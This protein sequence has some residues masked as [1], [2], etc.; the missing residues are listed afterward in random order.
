MR[1]SIV[2]LS[3]AFQQTRNLGDLTS[4]WV[5]YLH[6]EVKARGI[7]TKSKF[8]TGDTA[9]LLAPAALVAKCLVVSE[10]VS[11]G[12]TVRVLLLGDDAIA[13]MDRAMWAHY[14]GSFLGEDTTVKIY[15]TKDEL[16]TS[17]L[18]AVG[19]SLGLPISDLITHANIQAGAHDEFDLAVWVHPANEVK[20]HDEQSLISAL[21]LRD[22]GVP[23]LACVFNELD[24]HVQNY[25]LSAAGMRLGLLSDSLTRGSQTIN[26]FGISSQDAG[27]DGGWGAILCRLEP[28][29]QVLPKEDVAAVY[30]AAAMLRLEGAGS[31]S[32]HFGSRI[33][34]VAFNKIIPTALLGNMAIDD[35]T[36][37][38][39]TENNKPRI[40]NVVGHLWTDHLSRMPKSSFELLA[41]AAR[42]KLAYLSSL[43]KEEGKRTEAIAILKQ[44][45]QN[46][47]LD[48]AIGLARAYEAS[49]SIDGL[50]SAQELYMQVGEGH[51][52]SAY[53]VGHACVEKG[54]MEKA[55]ALLECSAAFGYPPATTDSGIVQCQ[56][57]K[58]GRGIATIKKAAAMGDSKANFIMAEQMIEEG[59]YMESLAP[60]RAAWSIGHVQALDTALWLTKNMMDK[61][62]GRRTELKQEL[63][64][65]DSFQKK[66]G[67]LESEVRAVNA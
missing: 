62:M 13:R 5:K 44:A 3:R 60:L 28:S 42:I 26:N 40:I 67:R 14:A 11:E 46:G 23:V 10:I 12:R 36:G 45:H 18:Y 57:G 66:R 64:D 52:M 8:S 37:Y 41:W 51:P 63:R 49:G 33:N 47:V 50:A 38:I 56:L 2:I 1:G 31:G 35:K 16:P 53:A 59:H 48:A 55:L 43:P 30:A 19:E 61:N 29:S 58:V 17:P 7:A 25:M 20:A 54:Q 65:L 6:A 32:W 4:A 34:G 39:L 24:L 9:S 27:I 22:R 15:Q 21:A